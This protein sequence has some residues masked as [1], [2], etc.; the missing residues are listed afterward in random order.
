MRRAPMSTSRRV[1]VYLVA[2]LLL[3][4]SSLGAL[5]QYSDEQ[6]WKSATPGVT[7]IQFTEIP[8]YSTVTDQYAALGVVFTPGDDFTFL[9]PS[10]WPSDGVGLKGGINQFGSPLPIV[11]EFDCDRTSIGWRYPAVTKFTL[12]A[13]G[14]EV[15]ASDSFF[16]FDPWSFAGVISDIPFDK[17]VMSSPL[18]GNNSMDTLFFGAPVPGPAGSGVFVI[19]AFA[20]RRRRR[21]R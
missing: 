2:V 18:G 13:D 9:N 15:G 11:M 8:L 7:T 5:V 10:L 16:G 19:A 12:Y 21:R 4:A 14:V 20:S 1:I 17:V 3:P 6:A